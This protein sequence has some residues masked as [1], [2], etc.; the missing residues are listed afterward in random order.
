MGAIYTKINNE[1]VYL[2]FLGFIN[3][4]CTSHSQHNLHLEVEFFHTFSVLRFNVHSRQIRVTR[5]G[6]DDNFTTDLSSNGAMNT[7]WSMG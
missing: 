7:N 5:S 4:V 3:P 6:V 2:F 1:K